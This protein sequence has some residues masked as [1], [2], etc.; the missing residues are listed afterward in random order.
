MHKY[1]ISTDR[2]PI[3][4]KHLYNPKWYS[5]RGLQHCSWGPLPAKFISGIHPYA[6]LTLKGRSAEVG[7]LEG[8]GH[9]C[10]TLGEGNNERPLNFLI[11]TL[12]ITMTRLGS[13]NRNIFLLL[14][15]WYKYVYIYNEVFKICLMCVCVPD[16]HLTLLSIKHIEH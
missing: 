6:L 11:S 9:L 4:Y 13:N 10:D 3:N 8:A 16:L 12:N 2:L 1:P 14:L 15:I 5:Y 7:T